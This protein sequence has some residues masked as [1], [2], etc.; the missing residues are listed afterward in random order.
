MYRFK[1][2]W[3]WKHK[4]RLEY[5]KENPRDIKKELA[6]EI[7]ALYHNIEEVKLAEKNFEFA[8]QKGI[9]PENAPIIIIESKNDDKENIEYINNIL[10]EKLVEINGYKSK[11]EVRRLFKQG[12]I[13]INNV[14]I[15]EIDKIVLDKEEN[16]IKIGK[17]KFFIVKIEKY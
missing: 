14:K 7:A 3:D 6:R 12:A 8:Y 2:F 13:T 1:N 4:K 17:G 15:L 9:I 10:I 5:G 11:N 16:V